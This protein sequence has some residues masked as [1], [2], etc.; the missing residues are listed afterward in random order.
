MKNLKPNISWRLKTKRQKELLRKN[1]IDD[2]QWIDKGLSSKVPL[3]STYKKSNRS[4][5]VTSKDSNLISAS[6]ELQ[7]RNLAL[8]QIKDVIEEV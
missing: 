6:G 8:K 2:K 1:G 5:K 3:D 7:V 4:G